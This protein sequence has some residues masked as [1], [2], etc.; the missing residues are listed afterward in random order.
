MAE[1]LKPIGTIIAPR[2][3]TIR[4]PDWRCST[5]FDVGG[6]RCVLKLPDRPETDVD[7]DDEPV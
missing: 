7:A 4:L 3:F 2:E 1:V 6:S 5:T